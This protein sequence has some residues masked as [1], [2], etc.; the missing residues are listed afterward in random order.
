MLTWIKRLLFVLILLFSNIDSAM[1]N[2]KEFIS[3]GCRH[4][5]MFSIFLDVLALLKSYDQR[6]CAGVEVDFRDEGFYYDRLHGHNW[7]HY[8]FEPI[9]MGNKRYRRE[10]Y[11][12]SIY[13][14]PFEIEYRTTRREAHELIQKYVCLKPEIQNAIDQFENLY[15][16]NKFV[17]GV[18]YRG[19]DKST[20]APRISYEKM[21][22]E[23]LNMIQKQQNQNIIIFVA[24]DEQNFIN[25]LISQF[26]EL[27]Y[28]I[29]NAIRST[30]G[31]AIHMNHKL[32]R[33]Q[34]GKEALIDCILL[35]RTNT[36]IRT[37]SNLSLCSTFFNP[38][39]P[40]KLLNKRWNE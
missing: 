13:V 20:E 36:L 27:V 17:I 35:S 1:A 30:D 23:I 32:P 29:P 31:L 12:C 14:N 38:D 11:G 9:S 26:G 22:E 25:F 39:L 37:N 16:R 8:Y 18:H 6:L 40:V 34:A 19:T 15:F 21:A 7:W 33:Y 4:A 10:V 5:G 28:Y 3:L 2:P 24:T